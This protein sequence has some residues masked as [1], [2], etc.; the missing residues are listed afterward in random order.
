M[1]KGTRFY[2]GLTLAICFAFGIGFIMGTTY[3]LNQCAD[4][5]LSFMKENNLTITSEQITEYLHRA[6]L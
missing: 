4:V 6:G 1:K 2:I 3:T 5:A